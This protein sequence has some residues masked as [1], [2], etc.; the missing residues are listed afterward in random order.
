MPKLSKKVEL[1]GRSTGLQLTCMLPGER[2]VNV[3]FH[4]GSATIDDSD[5]L[6]GLMTSP[7]RNSSSSSGFAIVSTQKECEELIAQAEGRT[8]K[9]AFDPNAPTGDL[10]GRTKPMKRIP[11]KRA[12]TGG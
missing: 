5:L 8:V 10:R 12:S 7:Y 1:A 2:R 3:D 9:A 11:K 4:Q 6:K